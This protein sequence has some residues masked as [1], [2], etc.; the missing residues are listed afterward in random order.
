M[1]IRNSYLRENVLQGNFSIPSDLTD[2]TTSAAEGPHSSSATNNN[3]I[4]A[5]LYY[6]SAAGYGKW[7]IL[8]SESCR[9]DL[10]RNGGQSEPV[11]KKLQYVPI[12]SLRSGAEVCGRSVFMY[13]QGTFVGLL[14]RN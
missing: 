10:A 12:T 6:E 9:R 14:L 11:L 2:F 13:L 4:Q 7:R 3:A 5:D 1:L 8:C